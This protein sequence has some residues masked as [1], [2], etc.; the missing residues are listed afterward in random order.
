MG[1]VRQD[2]LARA[3]S[4]S[5]GGVSPVWSTYLRRPPSCGFWRGRSPNSGIRELRAWAYLLRL[6]G[7]K[8]FEHDHRSRLLKEISLPRVVRHQLGC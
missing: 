5:R 6:S 8:R 7:G 4:F 3:V 2:H 1:C